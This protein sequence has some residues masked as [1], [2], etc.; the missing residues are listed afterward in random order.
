[1][2]AINHSKKFIWIWIPKNAGHFIY[3]HPDISNSDYSHWGGHFSYSEL[4]DELIHPPSDYFKFAF[5]RNPYSKIVSAFH[6]FREAHNFNLYSNFEDF[7]LENFLNEDGELGIEYSKTYK[8][9]YRR[10]T[11]EGG[12]EYNDHFETQTKFI[13]DQN[14][15]IA[16]DFIGKV[17]NI[18]EDFGKVCERLNIKK[19]P[20]RIINPSNHTHFMEYFSGKFSKRKIE[21][22]NELYKE[23]FYNFDYDM[24]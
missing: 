22:V 11:K 1:M 9:S 14:G 3:S 19:I 20:N 10:K 4:L 16:M 6:H 17:E 5:S 24:L 21:I 7:I 23:D 15:K 13:T 8:G 18:S 2:G 12:E